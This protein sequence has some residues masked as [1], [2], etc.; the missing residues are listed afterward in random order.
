MMTLI[1]QEIDTW[2]KETFHY[3]YSQI[4]GESSI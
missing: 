4:V 1:N 3:I 2:T